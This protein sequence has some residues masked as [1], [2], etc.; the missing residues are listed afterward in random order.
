FKNMIVHPIPQSRTKFAGQSGFREDQVHG[1]APPHMYPWAAQV[2]EQVVAVAARILQGVGQHGQGVEVA[3]F[4]RP[5]GD[6]YDRGCS[7]GGS[8]DRRAE[9][10]ADDVAEQIA[11]PGADSLPHQRVILSGCLPERAMV[12]LEIDTP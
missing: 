6:G 12:R 9:W 2:A 4:V 5:P 11:L 3:R 8:E 1:P 10:V 7:P